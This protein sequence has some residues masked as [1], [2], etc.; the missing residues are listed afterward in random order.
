MT[1]YINR[2]KF[3]YFKT[4]VEGSCQESRGSKR[5]RGLGICT[6]FRFTL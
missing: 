3:D 4:V 2:N 1:L 6:N 5:S